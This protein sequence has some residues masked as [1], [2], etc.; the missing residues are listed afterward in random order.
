MIC[1]STVKYAI[2]INGK[3]SKT[4]SPTRGIRQGD[5]ISP[6]LLLLC[7]E[8]LSALLSRAK[9]VGQIKG[10]K[11]AH[12]C[13]PISHLFFANNSLLFCKATI[14]EWQH[15]QTIL[16]TYEVASSQCIHKQKTTILFNSNTCENINYQI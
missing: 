3:T 6:Y 13:Q 10:V 16:A 15:V 4:F 14:T 9:N 11:V 5:P 12:G 1:V 2:L 8:G 7:V